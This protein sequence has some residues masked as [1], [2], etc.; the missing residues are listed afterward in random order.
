MLSTPWKAF[1]WV[2]SNLTWAPR[3]FEGPCPAQCHLCGSAWASP[4]MPVKSWYCSWRACRSWPLPSLQPSSLLLFEHPW[5]ERCQRSCPSSQLSSCAG[6]S[7]GQAIPGGASLATLKSRSCPFSSTNVCFPGRDRRRER[8]FHKGLQLRTSAPRAVAPHACVQQVTD[9]KGSRVEPR[10]V[11]GFQRLTGTKKVHGFPS[12][13]CPHGSQH[14][15]A[16]P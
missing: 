5:A 3:R 2:V 13:G 10:K 8:S 7:S 15:G 12:L 11:Y 1:P 4:Q 6:A 9:G 14:L 16:L